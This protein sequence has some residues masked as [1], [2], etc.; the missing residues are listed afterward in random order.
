LVAHFEERF[1]KT[2]EKF[3]PLPSN[4]E[5]AIARMSQMR[6]LTECFDIFNI[7]H[8]VTKDATALKIIT[9]DVIKA[10]SD[11][12]SLVAYDQTYSLTL[13]APYSLFHTFFEA[14]IGVCRGWCTVSRASHNTQGSA[15]RYLSALVGS[16]LAWQKESACHA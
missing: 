12:A 15:G 8:K 2:P 16:W 5:E 9:H 3:E 6:T 7:V 1:G 14:L 4:L 11:L 10:C 13:M